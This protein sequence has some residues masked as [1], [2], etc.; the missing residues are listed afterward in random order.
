MGPGAGEGLYLPPGMTVARASSDISHRRSH[1]AEREGAAAVVATSLHWLPVAFG[2][3]GLTNEQSRRR[4]VPHLVGGHGR[5][6]H[7]QQL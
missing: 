6:I 2:V 3:G 1:G 5:L 4:A 7:P